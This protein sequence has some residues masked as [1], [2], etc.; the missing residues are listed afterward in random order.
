MVP[1]ECSRAIPIYQDRS[2][3]ITHCNS[4]AGFM[5]RSLRTIS[6]LVKYDYS[7]KSMEQRPAASSFPVKS[8]KV[9]RV[10]SCYQLNLNMLAS[11]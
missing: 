4:T 9:N 5:A 1:A 3:L 11:L 10:M 8:L 7:I 6:R 2:S